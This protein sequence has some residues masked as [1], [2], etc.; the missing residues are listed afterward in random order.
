MHSYGNSSCWAPI[1][2]KKIT[3]AMTRLQSATF[4]SNRFTST[5]CN[6]PSRKRA[7]R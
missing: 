7:K 2:L 4:R 3:N 6:W 1:A 5:F